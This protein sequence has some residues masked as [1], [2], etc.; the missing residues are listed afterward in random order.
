MIRNVTTL[1]LALFAVA[2]AAAQTSFV[3]NGPY[4]GTTNW[5][6]NFFWS[7]STPP[8]GGGN[9]TLSFLQR[10]S[11]S[12]TAAN[13]LGNPFQLNA[14]NFNSQGGGIVVSS[15]AG[16]SLG[17]VDVTSNIAINQN[18]LGWAALNS[19][20]T[21]SGGNTVVGGTNFGNLQI[22]GPLSGGNA[23][24]INR[25][26]NQFTTGLVDLPAANPGFS[27]PVI[28]T[29]GNLRVGT[30]ALGTGALNT[31]GGTLGAAFDSVSLPNT[32]FL[33][34]DLVFSGFGNL[35]LTGVVNASGTNRGVTLSTTGPNALTL[36][37]TN[38]YVG[39]TTA[40]VNPRLTSLTPGTA[41]L[42][43][44][45]SNGSASLS[46]EFNFKGGASLTLDNS[47][48]GANNNRIGDAAPATMSGGRFALIG[49]SGGATF[50]DIGPLNGTG[51]VVVSV[52]AGVTGNTGTTLRADV[53]GRMDRGQFVFEANN[54]NFGGPLGAN[55]ANLIF[56]AAPALVGGG[57]VS[58]TPTVSIIPYAVGETLTT[59]V[60]PGLVTYGVNGVRLLAPSEY[61]TSITSGTSTQ[62]NVRVATNQSV[63]SPT[64]INALVVD[65]GGSFTGSTSTLT[66]ASGAVVNTSTAGFTIPAGM[67][68][69]F[70]ATEGVMHLNAGMVVDGVLT[71]TNGLTKAGAGTL[72][73]NNPL[74]NVSGPL[75]LN[76]GLVQFT[77]SAALGSHNIIIVFGRSSTSTPGVRLDGAGTAVVPK[78][79]FVID[80]FARLE[81][82]GGQMIYTGPI[83]GPGGVLIA[84]GDVA[85]T[86]PTNQ[87]QGQT[88]VVGG[89]LRVSGDNVLGSGGGVD[90]AGGRLLL[91]GDWT[92]SRP[93]SFSAGADIQID[94]NGFNWT[95]NS[96][97]TGNAA[98]VDKFGAGL[99]SLT[100]GGSLGQSL[101]TGST[102]TTATVNIQNG[103]LRVTNPTGSATGTA[104]V[105]VNFTGVLSGSGVN[106]GI[107]G[108]TT[109]NA[110]ASIRPGTGGTTIG[111]L[112]FRSTLTINGTYDVDG[113]A[114]TADQI[115]ALGAVTLGPSSVLNLIGAFDPGTT[116]TLLTG[117][118][119]TGAF[120]AVNGLPASHNLV[121]NSFNV[122]LVP[123]PEP[124]ATLAVAGLGLVFGHGVR[125][126]RQVTTR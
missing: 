101:F 92:T 36:Q 76:D 40:V 51:S 125:R 29:A 121:Y 82:G 68:L 78:S 99:W 22:G 14:L 21:L 17:F 1:A 27:G 86:N 105:N 44:S 57:G 33:N 126:R 114:T 52:N 115:N 103:E 25:P 31:Q 46:S 15:L 88:R 111:T 26:Q 32:M 81:S 24:V 73:L 35:T 19:P 94:T 13:N 66:V 69:A 91:T 112:N 71:G 47:S 123:V 9:F 106:S 67:T 87:Y 108:A 38:N 62:N 37:G 11:G 64:Q 42:T 63:T 113:A 50:E 109:I 16:N 8:A 18:G 84:G 83:S 110:S 3:W 90:F 98:R 56:D 100:Q 124:A 65:A 102:A 85:L 5:S 7:P 96:P 75:T 23:L 53:L 107:A 77:N 2:P 6:P 117:D 120:A 12:Y 80:G 43:L 59:G 48:A 119:M 61:T 39:P 30:N 95:V 54:G 60:G 49:S 72:I 58:G 34:S 20:A 116:F 89:T 10:G 4:T 74:N 79:L 55:V 28:I 70:G 41:S 122:Q 93:V 45:G 104:A 97:L 118:S